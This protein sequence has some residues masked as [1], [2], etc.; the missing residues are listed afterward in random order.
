MLLHCLD[1]H[2]RKE[3]KRRQNKKKNFR[4]TR[5][6]SF[7]MTLVVQTLISQFDRFYDQLLAPLYAYRTFT[8]PNRYCLQSTDMHAE[9]LRTTR[10]TAQCHR[11]QEKQGNLTGALP[12]G[13]GVPSG[14]GNPIVPSSS[15]PHPQRHHN[16]P[17]DGTPRRPARTPRRAPPSGTTHYTGNPLRISSQ[18]HQT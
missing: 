16:R 5:V 13:G 12:R 4:I 2:Q 14:R 11:E 1:M 10:I 18:S 17:A 8:T 15:C 7:S 3:D 6:D 9:Q